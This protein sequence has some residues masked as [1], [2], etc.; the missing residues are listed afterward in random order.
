M[1]HMRSGSRLQRL[2]GIEKL[3]WERRIQR[4]QPAAD[5]ETEI[6]PEKHKQKLES[7]AWDA[8]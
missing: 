3:V 6:G 1:L 2:E 4:E 5:R 7:M 8:V